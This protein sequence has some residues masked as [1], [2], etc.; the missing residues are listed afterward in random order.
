MARRLVATVFFVWRSVPTV[1]LRHGGQA[2]FSPT[3]WGWSI[4]VTSRPLP[5][6]VIQPGGSTQRHTNDMPLMSVVTHGAS[7]ASRCRV[8]YVGP[9]PAAHTRQSMHGRQS[10]APEGTTPVHVG[11]EENSSPRGGGGGKPCF[12]G[13]KK[14]CQKRV[15][16][17]R[18]AVGAP[19]AVKKRFE[20]GWGGEDPQP[21]K[22]RAGARGGGT[23]PPSGTG[24]GGTQA[25]FPA[26][27]S[28][29]LAPVPGP[30]PRLRKG[31]SRGGEPRTTKVGLVLG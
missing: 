11:C 1:W 25:R 13:E 24:P 4:E 19:C 12:K 22:G 29:S 30:L 14:R 20:S 2:P 17:I 31:G 3:L 5:A 27:E 18:K 10:Q 26:L 9:A 21:R 28:H 6:S 23:S 16:A 7:R 15:P 8:Q